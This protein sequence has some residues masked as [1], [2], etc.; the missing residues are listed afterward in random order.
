MLASTSTNPAIQAYK[1]YHLS[2]TKL[3]RE[4]R[5]Q[6]PDLHRIVLHASIVDNVRRWSRDL[7]SPSEA[8]V[9]DSESD[10]DSDPFEDSASDEEYEDAMPVDH[11][12]IF[13]CEVDDETM[14]EQQS[15]TNGKVYTVQTGVVKSVETKDAQSNSAP[16]SPRRRAPPPPSA[17]NSNYELNDQSWK[18]NRPVTVRETA[19]EVDGDD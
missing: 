2:Q 7:A 12:A 5:R 16:A 19:I 17:G 3:D 6:T 13:D 1:V 15:G 8:V 18:Q 11:V 14:I 10:T 4:C 9:V